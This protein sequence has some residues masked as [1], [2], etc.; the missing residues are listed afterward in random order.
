MS[1][2]DI[3]L[4]GE[5]VAVDWLKSKGY[6]ILNWDTR[7]PGATDIE[8]NTSTHILVQVKSAVYP[9]EVPTLS[10]EEETRIKAR[11]G[12]LSAS[13]YEARVQLDQNLHATSD[14]ITWRKL[15]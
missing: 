10:S 14:N 3:G 11:A 7:A 6:T 5:R 8:A 9:N 15:V 12:R 1:S 4:A 13:A 2:Y